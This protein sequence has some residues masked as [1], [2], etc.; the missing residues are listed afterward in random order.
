MFFFF[1]N[2]IVEIFMFGECLWLIFEGIMFKVNQVNG[3]FVIFLL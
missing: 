3:C 1:G 2:V